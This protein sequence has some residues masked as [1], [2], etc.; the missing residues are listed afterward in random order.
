MGFLVAGAGGFSAAVTAE[1]EEQEQDA[2]ENE[3][4]LRGHDWNGVMVMV[5]D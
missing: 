4:G 1:D 5:L 2:E 3:R